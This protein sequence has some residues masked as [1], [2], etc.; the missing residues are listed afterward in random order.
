M[1]LTGKGYFIWRVANCEGGDINAIA[2]RAQQCGYTHVLIKIADGIYSY[3]IVN[4]VELV[5]PLVNA[6]HAR[7][8]QA[9]G[10]HYLYGDDPLGEAN[11]AI[12]RIQT[13]GVDGYVMD[14]ETEYKEPGKAAAADTFL[15][16]LRTVLP[17]FPVA[18]C[19][20]RYHDYHQ[21]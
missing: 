2:N 8:I 20:Y 3:N 15:D 17:T 18:L 10:W 12:Q 6:L 19:S 9:W 5:T 11:K 16:R 14:V 4:N 7:G 1:T 13:T 21:E